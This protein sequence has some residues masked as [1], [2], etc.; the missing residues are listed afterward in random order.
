[1]TEMFGSEAPAGQE[2]TQEE[3]DHPAAQ[4]LLEAQAEYQAKDLLE[5]YYQSVDKPRDEPGKVD[6]PFPDVLTPEQ[7][8]EIINSQKMEAGQSLHRSTVEKYERAIDEF[9]KK[10]EKHTA[11]LRQ[12]LFGVGE[13]GSAALSQAVGADEEQPIKMIELGELAGDPTLAK[14]A[15]A[16]GAVRGD[17]PRAMKRYLDANPVAEALLRV[18]QQAPDPDFFETTKANI[19][20]MVPTPTQD[21]LRGRPRLRTY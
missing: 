20:R 3:V 19:T 10:A 8:A 16:A 4:A 1:M 15:F 12:D 21:Q 5:G 14:A 7:E 17:A 18:Y 13:G 11:K 6:L 2:T 9:A